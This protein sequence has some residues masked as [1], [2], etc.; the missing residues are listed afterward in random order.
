MFWTSCLVSMLAVA[1]TLINDVI[2]F[3]GV[4][5]P[6]SHWGWAFTLDVGQC[7]CLFHRGPH[8]RT[9]I[10]PH[11]RSIF[12]PLSK[13]KHTLVSLIYLTSPTGSFCLGTTTTR[14]VLCARQ[15]VTL[16]IKHCCYITTSLIPV[17]L[18]NYVQH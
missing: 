9:H 10:C 11:M 18:Y 15:K 12:Q 14:L 6:E 5:S 2:N 4:S 16:I 8:M 13:K 7:Y 1:R 17:L 3:L